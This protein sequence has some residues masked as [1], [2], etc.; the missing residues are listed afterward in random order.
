MAVAI[1]PDGRYVAAGGEVDDGKGSAQIWDC[2]HGKSVWSANDDQS[3]VLALAFTP[4]GSLIATGNAAGVVKLR[5][6]KTGRVIHSLSDH[7]G[8]ATSLVFS[9]DGNTL[10]CGQGYG[11]ARVWDVRYGRLLRSCYVEESRPSGF[12]IDRRMNSIGLSQDGASLATCASSVNDE[13]VDRVRIWD[14]ESGALKRDF[15]FH[16]Q[17]MALSPDGSIIATGGK[18]I[19]LWDS[20]TGKPLRELFGYLKRTQSIVFS[21]DGKLIVSGG[22]YGTTNLWDVSR[23]RLLATLFTFVDARTGA[24]SDNWLA[25]T[26]DGYYDGPAAV[27]RF[28]AWR[29]GDELQTPRTLAAQ[30]HK[31]DRVAAALASV[32]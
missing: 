27:E 7:K 19:K 13:F 22:S 25:Y 2:A 8:G 5:E 12:T 26:P 11:G 20:H 28:L 30:F 23:G 32:K 9:P 18:S 24:V 4:D 17:P 10:F 16:G 6:S 29:V 14:A 1:S 15:D 31:P 21:A 3:E